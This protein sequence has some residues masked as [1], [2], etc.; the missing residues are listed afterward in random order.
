MTEHLTK[1]RERQ[2]EKTIAER[3]RVSAYAPDGLSTTAA[4]VRF[5]CAI[6]GGAVFA[7]GCWYVLH[8]S[9]IHI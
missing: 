5:V 2:S 6:I 7:L 3:R 8:L 4:L 1:Q 9:L